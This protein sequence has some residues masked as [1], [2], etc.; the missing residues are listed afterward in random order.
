MHLFVDVPILGFVYILAS[1]LGGPVAAWSG[2]WLIVAW[3]QRFE[4]SAEEVSA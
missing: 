3:S 2:Q 1:G 4:R